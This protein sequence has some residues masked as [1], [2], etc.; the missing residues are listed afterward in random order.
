MTETYGYKGYIVAEDGSL[1]C[2]DVYRLKQ[3]D[4]TRQPMTNVYDNLN[5]AI[6][7][8]IYPGV[9]STKSRS[10]ETFNDIAEVN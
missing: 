6:E 5:D 2:C 8:T 3:K 10:W 9:V 7:R 4:G 1:K